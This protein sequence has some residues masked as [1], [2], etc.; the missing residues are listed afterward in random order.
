MTDNCRC[1]LQS[2]WSVVENS[3]IWLNAH[4]EPDNTEI[5]MRLL[6]VAEEAGEV[7]QAWIGTTGQ[8]PRKGITHTRHDV[9][10]EL[11]DVIFAA[12]V[13]VSSLGF[14]SRTVL[15]GKADT[16]TARLNRE[17]RV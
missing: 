3:V 10:A 8:N 4:H 15:I 12:L 6:K 13:A 11:A 17:V 9:A 7:A 1:D 14:D 5:A 2:V 16:L